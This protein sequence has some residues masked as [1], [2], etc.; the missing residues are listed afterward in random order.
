M[1]LSEYEKDERE[2]E[3][4]FKELLKKY[5]TENSKKEIKRKKIN[6]SKKK[7]RFFFE[8]LAFEENYGG[9]A[10]EKKEVNDENKE[11]IFTLKDGIKIIYKYEKNT[12]DLNDT[13]AK[14]LKIEKY[15]NDN[16][17]MAEYFYHY[18][19]LKKII[20]YNKDRSIN[21]INYFDIYYSLQRVGFFFL[22][23]DLLAEM[24]KYFKVKTFKEKDIKIYEKTDSKLNFLG[25]YPN[26][27]LN[28]NS[29]ALTLKILKD[30]IEVDQKDIES[31]INNLK[32]F[33][34][35]TEYYSNNKI[36]KKDIYKV[37]RIVMVKDSSPLYKNTFLIGK[38]EKTEYI[39][40]NNEVEKVKKINEY[41]YLRNTFW[42][43]YIPRIEYYFQEK[44]PVLEN[45]NFVEENIKRNFLK[46][47][48]EFLEELLEKYLDEKDNKEV[49][50]EK[51]ERVYTFKNKT[52]TIYKYYDLENEE[53]NTE[54]KERVY[55]FKNKTKIIHK[56]EEN[57]VD[58]DEFED[59]LLKIEKYNK[60]R[61]IEV[62]CFYHH[63][64][65]KKIIYYNKE[66]TIN[67]IDYFDIYYAKEETSL[68]YIYSDLNF[69]NLDKYFETKFLK[70]SDIKIYT[71]RE[72]GFNFLGNYPSDMIKAE[73]EALMLRTLKEN[74]KIERKDIKEY[75]DYFESFPTM[76]EYYSNGKI[77][78]KDIYKVERIM[79][80]S[81]PCDLDANLSLNGVLEKTEKYNDNNEI[82]EIKK[83]NRHIYVVDADFR[84]YLPRIEFN[85]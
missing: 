30:N 65:L 20:Y 66:Q 39:N 63:G 16:D 60:N 19:L 2:E 48:E 47:E 7:Q 10:L 21:N 64:F 37:E 4:I 41:I 3:I 70:E 81:H 34:T 35:I 76:T 24:N 73:K 77:I 56:Y 8:A 55:T 71:N 79:E 45:K 62:E 84:N 61:K 74:I 58:L 78:K 43:S 38:L 83:L 13:E 22:K 33:P 26:N 12:I 50:T 75:I 29:E 18:G 53:V 69:Y 15:D 42:V 5:H 6:P 9:N 59:E 52:K 25:N 1:L 46:Q 51:K 11:I 67:K 85:D 23:S 80:I 57:A 82:V 32:S 28:K 68:S 27:T 44:V 40:E 36:I 72:Y 49:N 14:F 54:K 31:F 17:I